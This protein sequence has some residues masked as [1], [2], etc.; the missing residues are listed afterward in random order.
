VKQVVKC[1][2]RRVAFYKVKNSSSL[3]VFLG[4]FEYLSTRGVDVYEENG[5][6]GTNIELGEELVGVIE[7]WGMIDGSIGFT[8]EYLLTIDLKI[9]NAKTQNKYLV[10]ALSQDVNVHQTL[11]G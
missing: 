3:I 5:K 1:S 4:A 11:C 7:R 6:V 2:L 9:E 8:S 10:V